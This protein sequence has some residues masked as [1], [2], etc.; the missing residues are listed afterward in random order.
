MFFERD[1]LSKKLVRLGVV[2][3]AARNTTNRFA[4]RQYRQQ[5]QSETGLAVVGM[6]RGLEISISDRSRT[7][8]KD[9]DRGTTTKDN[10][11]RTLFH[12]SGNLS[13]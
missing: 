3:G 13:Q 2:S 4:S 9:K 1:H 12:P 6:H 5:M 10:A 11:R 7:T 8:T